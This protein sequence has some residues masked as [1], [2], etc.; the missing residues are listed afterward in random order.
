M[1]R[2]ANKRASTN[3]G[4]YSVNNT[5][6]KFRTLDRNNDRLTPLSAMLKTPLPIEGK[7]RRL[8]NPLDQLSFPSTSQ[9]QTP[10]LPPTNIATP[11]NFTQ[12][13]TADEQTYTDR[14][15]FDTK[16]QFQVKTFRKGY[17]PYKNSSPKIL[18]SLQNNLTAKSSLPMSIVPNSTI[19]LSTQD[20]K[21]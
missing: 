11:N 9:P 3:I 15:F 1:S 12:E 7:G 14:S 20:A 10:L 13:D 21:L 8:Q 18:P 16:S 2:F 17:K 5:Q 6:T 19:V 4:H